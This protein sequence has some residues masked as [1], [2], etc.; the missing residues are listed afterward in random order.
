MSVL[1]S[2]MVIDLA[3]FFVHGKVRTDCGV[4]PC[5]VTT[6]LLIGSSAGD[7]WEHTPKIT[8]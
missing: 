1:S 7:H 6:V 3:H 2:C 8:Q 4:V 5:V